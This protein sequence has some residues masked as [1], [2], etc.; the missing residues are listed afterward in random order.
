MLKVTEEGTGSP[1]CPHPLLICHPCRTLPFVK[2]TSNTTECRE[3]QFTPR[4][5]L[6]M[7]A[8]VPVELALPP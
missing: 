6:L 4:Q 7:G 3:R 1:P 2:S 5:V 8:G